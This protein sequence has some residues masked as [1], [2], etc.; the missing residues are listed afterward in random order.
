MKTTVYLRLS[1]LI[2]FLVWGVCLWGHRVGVYR[3]LQ[4]LGLIRD[5]ARMEP[6]S[7]N[8]PLSSVV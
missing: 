8:V 2:P 7:S 1:I 4:R 5:E 3:F 6:A